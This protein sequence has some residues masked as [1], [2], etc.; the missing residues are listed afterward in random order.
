MNVALA[1][2]MPGLAVLDSVD[3]NIVRHYLD[4]LDEAENGGPL[5]DED[6]PEF[7]AEIERRIESIRNGTAKMTPAEEVFR[8]IDEKLKSMRENKV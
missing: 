3:R 2:V 4:E 7:V 1:N 5:D 8:R 6:D